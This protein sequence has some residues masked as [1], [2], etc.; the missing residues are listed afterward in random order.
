MSDSIYPGSRVRLRLAL[1]PAE[2]PE[3]LSQLD[4]E[5]LEFVMGDGTLAPGLELALYGLS[6]G[7]DQTLR[8][9]GE[10]AF[11]PRSAERILWMPREL[12]PAH[13]QL[14][15]GQIL[16]FNAPDG[17]ELAG[18]LLLLEPDRV[19]V[20]LNPPGASTELVLRVQVLEVET[21]LMDEAGF[22]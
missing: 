16:G 6:A 4:A 19:L 22:E 15:A 18:T 3:L 1:G 10:L 11:G 17:Q 8:M 9:A 20:D 21:P 5:P 13:L 7:D 12:F 14:E 2:A